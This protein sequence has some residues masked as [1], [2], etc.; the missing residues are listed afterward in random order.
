MPGVAAERAFLPD[1]VA[2]AP[3][4]AR[5]AAHLRVGAAGRRLPVVAF[6]VA[7]ELE[8]AGL[9]DCLELAG[10][11]ALAEERARRAPPARPRRRA[12][13]V[14][15]P[16]PAAPFADVIV[17]GEAEETL[18]QL[19]DAL[20]DEPDRAGAARRPG[21]AAR[22]LRARRSTASACR[23]SPRPTTHCLPA[24]SL[25]LTPHTE[26]RDMFL[27]EAERGCSRGC[28]YCVMRRSTNGGMRIV[29]P[30]EVEVADP[31]TTRGASAWSAPR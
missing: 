5:A 19:V 1:D 12:A 25:I 17:L 30:D 11:P 4:G 29:A 14:L 8:L 7:Y 20:R 9:I 3:R 16:A 10:I 26:L 23:R 22:L 27:I 6:S 2:Q 24:C 18:P 28:T 15:E 31:R 13:D 21:R